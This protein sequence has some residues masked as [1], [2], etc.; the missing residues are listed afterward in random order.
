MSGEPSTSVRVESTGLTAGTSVQSGVVHGGI[1]FHATPQEAVV[2]RQLPGAVRHFVNRSVEQDAL[3]TLLGGAR[4]EETP[5]GEAV[6]IS[7]I[8]GTAGVGKSTLVVHW[9]HRVRER[10]PDGE[11]YVNLRGFDPAADPMPVADALASLLAGLG[12]APEQQPADVEARAALLRSAAHGKRLLVLLDNAATTAQVRPLLPGSP[13]C[14]VVVTSRNRLE[15]LVIREGATRMTLDVLTPAEARE[16]LGRHLGAERLGAEPEAAEALVGHCAGLPL[17]L[18][19]VAYRAAENPDFPLDVLVAE[20][21]DEKER[22]DAL[23]LGG[24]TGVRSVFSWSYRRLSDEAA[25]MFRLLGLPTGPDIGLAAAADLAGLPQRRARTALAELTRAHLVEQH[26]PGRYRFHDL[27]RAYAA[28]CAADDETPETRQAALRRLLDHYLRTSSGIHS[29]VFPHTHVTEPEPPASEVVGL[30]FNSEETGSAW[31]DAEKSNL[32]AAI[33]Q[34]AQLHL[35]EHTWQLAHSLRFFFKLRSHTEDWI[36]TFTLALAVAE[37]NSIKVAEANLRLNLGIAYYMRKQYDLGAEYKLKAA[38]LFDK[39]NDETQ[40]SVSLIAAGESNRER[41][42]YEEA[43]ESMRRGL[44]LATK[45]AD[46]LLVGA[47][48]AGLGSVHTKQG[49]H[50]QALDHFHQALQLYH[51]Q[52]E[53]YG[54]GFVLDFLA[55]THLRSGNLEEAV[56]FYR[57]AAEHRHGIGDRQGEASSL[58]GLGTALQTSGDLEGAWREWH[59]AAAIFEELGDEAADEVHALLNAE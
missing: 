37:E 3:T 18:G 19:I 14:L 58:R 49:K 34:A 57:R 52:G 47:A 8:D 22:L 16:L 25:S 42:H 43:A 46:H 41:A 15:D 20:L 54:E 38:D 4:G 33:H 9:A 6:V 56:S 5:G 31:W 59:R 36:D 21:R 29:Q 7:A 40:L 24:E 53:K 2:P 39:L 30:T 50:E 35:A 17:A 10:F 28:E 48:H 11:L 55:E 23:D 12:I 26:Q 1:H 45:H 44:E 32:V 51:E 13:S 27:L